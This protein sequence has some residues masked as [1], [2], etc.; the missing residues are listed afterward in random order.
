MLKVVNAAVK[1]AY[2]NERRIEWME[3]FSGEKA[4]KLY[5]LFLPDET[6]HALREFVVPIKGPLGTPDRRRHPLAQRGDG[7]E[8]RSLRMR[9]ADPIFPRRRDLDGGREPHRHG[10]LPREHGRH[11]CRHRVARGIT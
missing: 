11:L 7:A 5:E 8:P 4:T 6:P 3:I 9:A 10:G 2:G 1:K